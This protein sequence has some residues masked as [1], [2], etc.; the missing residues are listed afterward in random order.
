VLCYPWQSR[1]ELRKRLKELRGLGI[2]ALQFSGEKQIS[3]VPILGKGCVGVVTLAYAG[4]ERMALKIRRV[5]ADRTTMRHEADMLVKANSVNVGPKLCKSSRNFLLTEFVDGR[6][7]PEWL[8]KRR[9]K[10]MTRKLLYGLIF[11]CRRLDQISLDHGELSHAPKH[12]IVNRNNM[13]V[14]VDFETASLNRRPSNLT[15][16]CQYLFVSGSVA[17]RIARLLGNTNK[18]KVVDALRGY[19]KMRDDERFG[20]VLAAVDL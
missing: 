12:V 1:S 5:D 14:I 16:M 11:Q 19:K 13:P 20:Q 4:S 15:S 10:K 18:E 9:G 17:E 3:G 2:R 7:L 8:R 6:L